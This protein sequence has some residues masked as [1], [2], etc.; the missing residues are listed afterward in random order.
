[1]SLRKGIEIANER[2][3]SRDKGLNVLEIGCG[4][5]PFARNI[6]M[7][8]NYWWGLDMVEGISTNKGSIDN[9]P[10]FN[11]S[12]DLVLMNQVLEHIFEYGI[13][14]K[15]AFDEILRVLKPGGRLIVTV[16]IGVHGHP[17]FLSG[18]LKR[19]RN[20]FK[21]ED[22]D[23]TKFEKLIPYGR[24]EGWKQIAISGFWSKL[25]YPDFLVSKNTKL[26]GS[27]ILNIHAKKRYWLP[28][29]ESR[30]RSKAL[31]ILRFLKELV[32]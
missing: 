32:C 5:W 30:E 26:T 19:I 7:K 15:K 11:E 27:Y 12:F 1:M 6:L 2:D 20:L 9:I 3:L 23:I 22:W 10:F 14:F 21:K 16:P 24:V 4:N 13:S 25:Q 17:I 28:K 18:N 8:N 29:K 31:I